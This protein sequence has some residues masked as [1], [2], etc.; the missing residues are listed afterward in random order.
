LKGSSQFWLVA[1]NRKKEW[2][3]L[4]LAAP[5]SVVGEPDLLIK[6]IFSWG[7]HHTLIGAIAEQSP[8]IRGVS[9][10]RRQRYISE[11]SPQAGVFDRHQHFDPVIK[12]ALHQIRAP[13][14]DFLLLDPTIGEVIDPAMLEESPDQAHYPDILTYARN[15]WTQ[16]AHASHD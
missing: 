14:Q 6:R 2:H 8:S 1:S 16:A 3:S 11:V 15:P 7:R 5:G 12:V 10:I 13:N 9:Q 4:G